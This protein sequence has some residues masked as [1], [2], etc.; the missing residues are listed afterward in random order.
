M[1]LEYKIKNNEYTTLRQILKN[2]WNISGRLITKL[3]MARKLFIN[4]NNNIYLDYKLNNGDIIL[5]Y[6]DFKEK[7]E[8][9][10]ETKMDLDIIYED[11]YYIVINKPASMPVHP[12]C[13]HYTDSLSNGLKYYYEKNN[14]QTK[15][16]PVNRI[17]KDT[18]G[19][20]IFAKNEYIQECLIT[21]MKNKTFE[22]TYIAILDGNLKKES[23]TIHDPIARKKNSII[24]RCINQENGEIAITHFKLIENKENY[25]IVEFKLET[26]KNS[27]NT[28]TLQIYWSS[29]TRRYIIQ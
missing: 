8:N 18:S 22:K 23:G 14:I 9:I 12:S 4:G 1:V 17:D 7:S 21:Q 5:V 16:R 19:I 24:E 26:R 13:M 28:C 10:V 2:K 29:N 6:I 3:K 15:I 25:C 27:S 11:E 20:V